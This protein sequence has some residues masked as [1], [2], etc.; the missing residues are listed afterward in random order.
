[1]KFLG[2]RLLA[3]IY[4]HGV[5]LLASI[6]AAVLLI[7]HFVVR[8]AFEDSLRGRHHQ[9][10]WRR[11][12]RRATVEQLLERLRL[13]NHRP[14]SEI[15]LYSADG[16]V[17]ASTPTPCTVMLFGDDREVLSTEGSV[18]L[19]PGGF[20]LAAFR[21][22]EMVA[23]AITRM[24]P[25]TGLRNGGLLLGVSL[26]ALALGSIP[27]A[28]SLARPVEELAAAT[29]RLGAG[30]MA[31]RADAKRW[32]EL[33]DLARD[34]NAM[35]DRIEGLR[36]KEKELLA[37]VSHELRTPLARIR[38]VL[39]LAAEGDPA[40]ARGFLKEIASDLGEVEHLVDDIISTA[41]LDLDSSR[42]GEPYPRL[43][44]EPV[45]VAELVARAAQQFR[46]RCPQRELRCETVRADVEVSG[47]AA[48]LRR[49]LNNLLDNA[50]KYSP[51]HTPIELVVT[52]ERGIVELAVVD[53][54]IG[55]SSD[56][57]PRLFSPFFRADR[58]RTRHT[59]G[60]GLG[61]ALSKRIVDAHQG[62]IV[63]ESELGV[64]TTMR[65]RL[66]TLSS[67]VDGMYAH[68]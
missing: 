42:D 33:G 68:S 66:P 23:Y 54:G 34:F 51:D 20:A 4:L 35:A 15:S 44:Q 47:D 9:P 18:R 6:G 56:D 53:A 52:R 27:L 3:R 43:R 25:P 5:V 37:D 10:D 32:D 24:P 7:G 58:S 11:F 12:E 1:M 57:Q 48:L 31:A 22:G 16:Q 61:L 38:V 39:D 29:R 21:D 40:A 28:R 30:D 67:G 50:D 55:I 2:G 46:D 63:V 49:V 36:R 14:G 62:T 59:G 17:L 65:V 26:V 45:V 60:V 64:G 8:P 13:M 41:R 19:G